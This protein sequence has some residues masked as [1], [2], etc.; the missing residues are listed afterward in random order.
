MSTNEALLL[1]MKMDMV[2]TFVTDAVVTHQIHAGSNQLEILQRYHNPDSAN[3]GQL[4]HELWAECKPPLPSTPQ[5]VGYRWELNALADKFDRLRQRRLIPLK[6]V[7]TLTSAFRQV[8]TSL[9]VGID[10]VHFETLAG[11]IQATL[12]T[13]TID[14]NSSI[15]PRSS[16]FV[17]E[18]RRLYELFIL[19]TSLE[20]SK[21]YMI[22]PL[23]DQIAVFTE[24][25][26]RSYLPPS[27]RNSTARYTTLRNIATYAFGSTSDPETLSHN[28]ISESIALKLTKSHQI[29]LRDLDHFKMELELMGQALSK[30]AGKLADLEVHCLAQQSTELYTFLV[31]I[32]NTTSSRRKATFPSSLQ[33]CFQNLRSIESR[34]EETKEILAVEWVSLGLTFL[35]CYV[36]S[37]PN[38]P[39]LKRFLEQ[40]LISFQF[41]EL[42]T[43]I[44][45]L[46]LVGSA[47]A[48]KSKT[49]RSKLVED[50]LVLFE[51]VEEPQRDILKIRPDSEKFR[52]LQREFKHVLDISGTLMQRLADNQPMN[53]AVMIQNIKQVHQR[54]ST[55]Y[56]GLED[57]IE[58]LIGFLG[59]LVI[60]LSLM[61]RSSSQNGVALNHIQHPLRLVLFHTK[62]DQLISAQKTPMLV[63]K[64][65][66]L[67]L[68]RLVGDAEHD[69][70]IT[71]AHRIFLELYGRWKLQ[72]EKAQKENVA[73]SSLYTFQG[74]QDDDEAAMEK[75]F[76]ELFPDDQEATAPTQPIFEQN[77]T[78][79][80]SIKISTLHELLIKGNSGLQIDSIVDIRSRM[81]DLLL[82]SHEYLDPH[83]VTS[84][85]PATLLHIDSN[86]SALNYSEKPNMEFYNFYTDM[87]LQEARKMMNLVNRVRDRFENLA[88]SWPE[89]ATPADV[90]RICSEI[91]EFRHVEPVVKFLSKSEK[92]HETV[93][94]WQK[95]ASKEYSA[96]DVYDDLT[97]LLVG[98]RKLELSTWARLLA[99]EIH[100]CL[101][102][103]RSWWFIAYETIIHVPTQLS[104]SDELTQSH[105]EKT[106]R[107]IQTFLATT[108]LGEFSARLDLLQV[109]VLDLKRGDQTSASSNGMQS[110][111]ASLIA[112][113]DRYRSSV[114]KL[115]IK[116]R[117]KLE[118]D[119]K[120]VILLASWKDVNID[121]L[122][123]SAKRSHHK[124]FKIVR[125]FRKMLQQPM[126]VVLQN[127]TPEFAK[128]M[129]QTTAVSSLS[130]VQQ[131]GDQTSSLC[132]SIFQDWLDV[133][134]RFRNIEATSRLMSSICS[135]LS[136]TV[137][138]TTILLEILG[139]LDKSISTLQ[140]ETPQ[141]LTDENKELVKHLKVRK[142]TLFADILKELRHMGFQY[143]LP[144]TVLE[145]QDDTCKIIY[146][147]PYLGKKDSK[148]QLAA[149]NNYFCAMLDVMPKIRDISR[150]HSGDLTPAE[151]TRSIGYLEGILNRL[152]N[153]RKLLARSRAANDLIT[154]GLKSITALCDPSL[155]S[156]QLDHGGIRHHL[157]IYLQIVTELSPT[158]RLFADIVKAKSSLANEDHAGIVSGLERAANA[159]DSTQS[160]LLSA[161]E[162]PKAFFPAIQQNF[163]DECR[164]EMDEFKL[165]LAEWCTSDETIG[166][167][168]T[169]LL[170]FCGVP[171]SHTNGLANTT[172]ISLEE[173]RGRL[174]QRVD[175]ML[176]IV[177]N[178]ESNAK[179]AL[180]SSEEQSWLIKEDSIRA[181]SLQHLSK[182]NVSEEL[183][184]CLNDLSK[185]PQ[186]QLSS[187]IV[188]LR[189]IQPVVQTYAA[190]ITDDLVAYT[191]LH[192]ASSKFGYQLS[193]TFIKIGTDGFCTPPD[194]S[195]GEEG[196]GTEKLEGGTGLGEGEGAENIS[197][198]IEEDEDLTE[199]AETKNGKDDREDLGEDQDAVD[200]AD[201]DLEGQTEE[202]EDREEQD[203]DGEGE[204]DEKEEEI[205][206][207]TGD[208]DDLGPS[209]VDE[210]M[211]DSGEAAEKDKKADTGKG[212]KS[213]EMAE[214]GA[215]GENDDAGSVEEDQPTDEPDDVAQ[216][217]MEKAD[218]H[219]KETENLDLPED[220]NIDNQSEAE[221]LG[222]AM[223][224]MTDDFDD[225]DNAEGDQRKDF[226]DG[227]AMSLDGDSEK[228][229]DADGDGNEDDK[230]ADKEADTGSVEDDRGELAD[231]TE[232]DAGS[233]E[234]VDSEADPDEAPLPLTADNEAGKTE[235]AVESDDRGGGQDA[236]E[237]SSKE[238]GQGLESNEPSGEQK[239][240]PDANAG[241]AEVADGDEGEDERDQNGMG[242]S[243]QQNAP[244]Q[245]QSFKK[246]GDVLNKWLRQ[247]RPIQLPPDE[248]QKQDTHEDVDMAN[249]DVDFEHM[250]D[251]D[252]E[253]DTQALGTATQEQAK[254]VDLDNSDAQNNQ[255]NE[256]D[257][258]YEDV[259]EQH[260]EEELTA[261][262]ME[263]DGPVEDKAQSRSFI[264]NEERRREIMETAPGLNDDEA[265][266]NEDGP[267][268]ITR[269]SINEENV[270]DLPSLEVSRALWHKHESSTRVLSAM[271]A[272][273][274][275]LI[276]APTLAT[277]LR[278]DFRTGKRL[279]IKRIIPYIASSYKRDKIWM[280][281]SVPS[282]RSYQ[283]MIALD[284]SQSMADDKET[285]ELSKV[286]LAHQTI[287][288]IAKSLSVLE[289]GDLSI[290]S[291]GEDLRI[292]HPFG[293]PFSDDAGAHIFQNFGFNQE[294]TDVKEM[295]RKGIDMFREARRL[296][297]G[298]SAQLWQLLLIVSDGICQD[299]DY[300][301]RQV[302]EA[303]NER[304]MIVFVIVDKVGQGSTNRSI[305]DLQTADFKADGGGVMKLH[306][307]VYMDT[308]PFRWWLVVRD[309]RELPVVLSTALRQWF[310]E[311]ADV[312]R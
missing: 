37:R 227:E 243:Q 110:A 108:S 289:T 3:S 275:R 246:L 307:K 120:E 36:P 35:Q 67:V 130:L 109:F 303:E 263:I 201:A 88:K 63:K 182:T 299:H 223:D 164:L 218:D 188:L 30:G 57:I 115:I 58:P 189:H 278:G 165:K 42:S 123:E 2:S 187:A 297:H 43:Q 1:S 310:A 51:K 154:A 169:Q 24:E 60:G 171:P 56:Q 33:Q 276:L 80:L 222:S 4:L 311:T 184:G 264:N 205:D 136:P 220:M 62:D 274:L 146:N 39:L 11:E 101:D 104:L 125:K 210:K 8:L 12:Q 107:T 306:R 55:N 157:E 73:N 261:N 68:K 52:M 240:T 248:P 221:S 7:V 79:D 122:R 50:R 267:L 253:A 128:N 173:F 98:W 273:Q 308:F 290:V 180:T 200:M 225:L 250:Q 304:I 245:N 26:T 195:T 19:H 38:D 65:D 265:S 191:R 59:I 161:L 219:L 255:E 229:S 103:A 166:E 21:Q 193:C 302:R 269:M 54:L 286:H 247:N 106:I 234:P 82:A 208:V 228:G 283:I 213:E 244:E 89:H 127:G 69:R 176:A 48:E 147:L 117:A 131:A 91:M 292:A 118:K 144:F 204:V 251:D 70:L 87:N 135:N 170:P 53:D 224:D 151:V 126:S 268:D 29:Q 211:W 279:N 183:N 64:V 207:E 22:S 216:E 133:K 287:A 148:S 178:L 233:E 252:Q 137:D 237:D 14:D 160:K 119:L 13:I 312:G 105:T 141:T 40:D 139:S 236:N 257:Q 99:F 113:Y 172:N 199:L 96:A 175:T 174:F 15:E 181:M 266:D 77:F 83:S 132:S 145:K 49:I 10:D 271:L 249:A 179:P 295:L 235:D 232:A 34:A 86:L 76:S 18:F 288:L 214:A 260:D 272:E 190:I 156:V 32:E 309:V 282:K 259:I 41:K 5:T 134:A 129:D 203:K 31:N 92:L 71:Y 305:M 194:K 93:Y 262:A 301:V 281:R 150:E 142:R 47:F 46:E 258:F 212:D 162:F 293:K 280:R 27:T 197:N 155:E 95:V 284:D 9:D 153:Q 167:I 230:E 238:Q 102:N 75:E 277:K 66:Q 168:L 241:A 300:I 296:N 72:L 74:H 78:R 186:E 177:Q 185:V 202:V 206:E 192:C 239:S 215:D 16:T 152:L 124:L 23:F 158:C 114:E 217:G 100:K 198:D 196:G 116:E 94:Q 20:G 138:G 285:A 256:H 45:S 140:K 242:R 149:A 97:K 90:L 112:Y 85:L 6:D 231:K 25:P 111:L 298:S 121:A 159:F 254:G 61:N 143:N 291:F 17:T 209:A 163:I 81:K 270:D 28:S 226:D 84:S 294:K 44:A